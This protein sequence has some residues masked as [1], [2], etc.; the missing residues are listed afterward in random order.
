VEAQARA[1]ADTRSVGSLHYSQ[2]DV[3]NVPQIE[4]TFAA[5]AARK[6]RLDGLIAAAA[7]QRVQAAIDYSQAH[8][9]EMMDVNYGGVMFAAAA[10]ARQ[11]IACATPGN[12]VLV[13]SMSGKITNKGLSRRSTIPARRL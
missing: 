8:M 10:A 1:A 11:M 9:R 2:V 6:S 12:I 4:A 13:A 5:I 7:I 3:R